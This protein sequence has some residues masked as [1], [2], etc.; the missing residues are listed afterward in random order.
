MQ[1]EQHL[2]VVCP[3]A[4]CMLLRWFPMMRCHATAT[5]VANGAGAE[6]L[7]VVPQ[8]T[9]PLL[10]LQ[11]ALRALCRRCHLHRCCHLRRQALQAR[12]ALLPL[13]GWGGMAA[14]A[15]WRTYRKR[16]R[17]RCR[18]VSVPTL[19]AVTLQLRQGAP[20]SPVATA[21]PVALRPT[22]RRARGK[23]SIPLMTDKQLD[24]AA[25]LQRRRRLV[26]NQN[27][28]HPCEP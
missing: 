14:A 4:R 24:S 3:L 9:Q 12:L 10:L 6:H 16:F 27:R 18:G 23:H 20:C 11:W 22:H 28:R 25:G 1:Q 13:A 26:V 15:A 17:G 8:G 5:E 21:P 19:T 7:W 2:A